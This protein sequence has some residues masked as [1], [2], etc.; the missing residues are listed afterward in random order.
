[1]SEKNREPN[2]QSKRLL[3]ATV[4]Q[5]LSVADKLT[6][7]SFTGRVSDSVWR[8]SSNNKLK[9]WK[10]VILLPLGKVEKDYISVM[11][12]LVKILDNTSTNL[13]DISLKALMCLQSLL[14]QKT[15]RRSK[16]KENSEAL[17]RRLLIWK[18][19]DFD[20]LIK[21]RRDSENVTSVRSEGI[22]KTQN[23]MLEENSQI[24]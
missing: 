6:L 4:K 22:S 23:I 3:P 18:D 7:S 1:M 9:F 24:F 14:L 11:I 13:A 10:N 8:S 15:R 16:S 21:K 20:K 12:S 19:R 2:K 5:L 17:R